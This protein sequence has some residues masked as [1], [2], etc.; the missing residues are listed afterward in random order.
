MQKEDTITFRTET[1]L[2]TIRKLKRHY[3]PFIET[4]VNQQQWRGFTSSF[5]AKNF[6]LKLSECATEKFNTPVRIVSHPINHQNI[7]GENVQIDD[8]HCFCN[9]AV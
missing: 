8:I 9:N 7:E 6:D 4:N 1:S 3:L 5:F 2:L